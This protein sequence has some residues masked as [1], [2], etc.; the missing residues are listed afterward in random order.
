[1]RRRYSYKTINETSELD[2]VAIEE[3][4]ISK[5]DFYAFWLKDFDLLLTINDEF[6]HH[7]YLHNLDMDYK[8]KKLSFIK[9]DIFNSLFLDKISIF[10]DVSTDDLK[11]ALTNFTNKKMYQGKELD[12]KFIKANIF[13]KYNNKKRKINRKNF[14]DIFLKLLD[15]DEDRYKDFIKHTVI[16][17]FTA[18]F[19]KLDDMFTLY[20]N[21]NTIHVEFPIYASIDTRWY[22]DHKKDMYK[23]AL[24][25][26]SS[27]DTFKKSC[28]KL[29]DFKLIDV[30]NDHE[31]VNFFFIIKK[32]SLK[33]YLDNDDE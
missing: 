27:L 21:I 19:G 8:N 22:N 1:M 24:A 31:Y 10:L 25:R 15:N 32:D 16:S 4:K 7:Y 13:N 28:M 2:N 14:T 23:Y 30:K 18:S 20:H 12:L 11:E 33:E 29:S 26:I 9:I 5:D 3:S 17:S 6:M